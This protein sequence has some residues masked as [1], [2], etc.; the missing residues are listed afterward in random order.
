MDIMITLLFLSPTALLAIAQVVAFIGAP[1]EAR[2]HGLSFSQFGLAWSLYLIGALSAA[3]SILLAVHSWTRSL[4]F[5]PSIPILAGLS[6]VTVVAVMAGPL[7]WGRSIGEFHLP[8][9]IVRAGLLV[10]AMVL[11]WTYVSLNR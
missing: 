1:S 9:H 10:L 7:A 4:G 2:N 11:Y 3:T 6:L 5:M 8:H